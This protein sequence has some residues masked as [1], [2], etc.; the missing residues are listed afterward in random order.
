LGDS[1]KT[2]AAKELKSIKTDIDN[3]EKALGGEMGAIEQL[4][5][6]LNIITEIKNKSMDMEFRIVEVQEQF[7]VLDMY[8]YEIEEEVRKEVDGLMAQ[9]EQL[10][11]YADKQDFAVNDF[12][13]NFAEVTKQDVENFKSK[14]KEEFE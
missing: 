10:L 7:R 2:I 8:E 9:W 4:K 3:Y 14:I 1:L 13:K 6:L 11:E 5:S 12:K